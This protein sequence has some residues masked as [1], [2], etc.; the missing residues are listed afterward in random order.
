VVV[1]LTV[2]LVAA[3]PA[4]RAGA[5]PRVV[6]R[7]LQN[8]LPRYIYACGTRYGSYVY[9][10]N[11]DGAVAH[12][13]CIQFCCEYSRVPH[14]LSQQPPT[15][16]DDRDQRGQETNGAVYAPD[17]IRQLNLRRG[18]R[19]TGAVSHRVLSS[20]QVPYNVSNGL[21]IPPPSPLLLLYVL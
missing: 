5:G 17:G 10:N 21:P 3:R 12:V 15:P 1:L 2:P 16:G 14:K 9:N 18:W 8:S 4:I 6:P 13:Q 19:A 11:V 7:G 20:S